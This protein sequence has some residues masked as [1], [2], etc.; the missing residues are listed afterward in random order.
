MPEQDVRRWHRGWNMTQ[1]QSLKALAE[2]V[3]ARKG[4]P[5][6]E[7][8]TGWNKAQCNTNIPSCS[9]VSE[10]RGGT[11]EQG[12]YDALRRRIRRA[13]DWGDLHEIISD[14]E[15]AFAAGQLT[16]DDVDGLALECAQEAHTL[17][18]HAPL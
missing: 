11:P 18:K 1:R 9:A 3:L 2:A 6:R 15:C 12:A 7:I 17:P 13:N 14:A 8:G 10:A 4:E 5:E 16:G